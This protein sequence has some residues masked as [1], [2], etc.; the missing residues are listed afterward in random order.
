MSR[1]ETQIWKMAKKDNNS[2]E[3]ST[4]FYQPKEYSNLSCEANVSDSTPT[5]H[6]NWSAALRETLSFNQHCTE[7][8][9]V[10]CK[11]LLLSGYAKKLFAEDEE[12]FTLTKQRK[13]SVGCLF[14][15]Y[16]DLVMSILQRRRLTL[17]DVVVYQFLFTLRGFHTEDEVEFLRTPVNVV[18]F[19]SG[20]YHEAS[21]GAAAEQ[22]SSPLRSENIFMLKFPSISESRIWDPVTLSNLASISNNQW[23]QVGIDF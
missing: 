11:Q 17:F 14:Q 15:L 3:V 4:T 21:R 20:P 6:L 9:S 16:S 1:G 7:A 23:N 12:W 5:Q 8:K 18:S 2:K 10:I 13:W 22:K 19:F